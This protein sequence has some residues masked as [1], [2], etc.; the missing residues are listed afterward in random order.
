MRQMQA[1]TEEGN[2]LLEI[3]SVKLNLALTNTL[4]HKPSYS[5]VPL[6]LYLGQNTWGLILRATEGPGIECSLTRMSYL[7]HKEQGKDEA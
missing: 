7:R 4:G 2:G 3:A 5:T 1:Q 6:V